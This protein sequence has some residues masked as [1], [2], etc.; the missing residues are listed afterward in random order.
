MSSILKIHSLGNLGSF[1]RRFRYVDF[2]IRSSPAL[3]LAFL[4]Y[5]TFGDYLW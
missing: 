1:V 5:I 2:L 3:S 4:T